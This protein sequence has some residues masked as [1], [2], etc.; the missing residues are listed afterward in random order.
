MRKSVI[1]FFGVL[2]YG[3]SDKRNENL[4][5]ATAAN[6][7]FAME[8]IVK[9]FKEETGIQC[10][11]ILGSSGQLSAQIKSGAPYDVFVS[12]NMKYPQDIFEN[13]LAIRKPSIYAYG[14]LVLWTHRT[15]ISIRD[16]VSNSI[17]KIAIANPTTAPYGKAAVDALKKS[18]LL[19][20]VNEKLV[21]GESISQVNQF[22]L[23]NAV[24][25][26]FT[27]KSVVVSR[28]LENT[29]KWIAIDQDLYNPIEQGIVV[30]KGDHEKEATQFF[31]FMFSE[32]GRNILLANGYRVN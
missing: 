17:Q 8:E 26:G 15:S 12:A 11:I 27:S 29:G 1:L 21:Y 30:I 7:Q 20:R 2:C 9:S 23:S 31:D 19:D 4:I 32:K 22:I 28:E 13:N 16:L 18:D 6:V 10:E 25:A 3:C 14:V 5:I 24:D